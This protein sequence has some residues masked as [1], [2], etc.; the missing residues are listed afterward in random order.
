MYKFWLLISLMYSIGI[1]SQCVTDEY[2]NHLMDEGKTEFYQESKTS[3]K[4][5]RSGQITIP[6]VFHIV[7]DREAENIPDYVIYQQLEVLNESFNLLNSDTSILTDTLKRL[8]DN[9]N[10]KFELAWKDPEG[11]ITNGITRQETTRPNFAYFTQLHKYEK[12]GT[13]VW[14][15]DR[16]LNIWVCDLNYFYLGYAQFPGGPKETDGIT[17]HYELVGNQKYPWCSNTYDGNYGGRI[18]VHE[19]GHWLSL[20]HPWGYSGYCSDD[21]V[22]DTPIQYGP[23]WHYQNCPDVLFSECLGDSNRI[24]VKNYMDYSGYNCMVAFTPGQV[25]KGLNSLYVMRGEIIDNYEPRPVVENIIDFKI[26]QQE[27]E[28]YV[29]LP[30]HDEYLQLEIFDLNGRLL[31]NSAINKNVIVNA[32]GSKLVDGIYLVRITDKITVNSV[33]KFYKHN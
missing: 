27:S 8:V 23:V 9:F 29:M 3:Q 12:H 19:V 22:N 4:S 14:D 25:A 24:L 15:P 16:Y 20:F 31:L 32:G 26:L 21:M 10:I 30:P 28:I 13:A 5:L 33:K 18:L 11:N 1:K 17:M 6:V 7:Y 2:N